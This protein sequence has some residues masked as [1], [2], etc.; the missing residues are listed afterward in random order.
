MRWGA[1]LVLMGGLGACTIGPG[2]QVRGH[3]FGYVRVV[4]PAAGPERAERTQVETVGA[5][6]ELAP[7]SPQIDSLG[8]GLRRAKR[9]VLPMDCRLA[10][11]VENEAQLSAARELV[12]SLEGRDACAIDATEQ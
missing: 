12:R 3:Y 5:W 7:M 10:I 2:E 4:E 11:I 8:L 9:T 6:L 1:M